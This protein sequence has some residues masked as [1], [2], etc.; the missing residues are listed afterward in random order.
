MMR[1]LEGLPMG[2]TCRSLLPARAGS[3]YM[4]AYGGRTAK[5]HEKRPGNGG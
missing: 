5:V 2:H 4:T 3:V 1:S